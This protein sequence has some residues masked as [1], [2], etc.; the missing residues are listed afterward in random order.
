MSVVSLQK[1]FD[2][3]RAQLITARDALLQKKA[4]ELTT[5]GEEFTARVTSVAFGLEISGEAVE[6]R[7]EQTAAEID[8]GSFF[9]EPIFEH[10]WIDVLLLKPEARVND[11]FFLRRRP[12]NCGDHV[13]HCSCP[14]PIPLL[15]K[16]RRAS[17]RHSGYVK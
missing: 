2:V 14:C 13:A 17:K 1:S 12:E 5:L 3:S 11:S 9:F 16:N 10:K 4:I 8:Q 7:S 6:M 15:E